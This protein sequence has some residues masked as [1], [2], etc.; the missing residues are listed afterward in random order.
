MGLDGHDARDAAAHEHDPG[1]QREQAV[2]GDGVDRALDAAELV[3]HV[4]V[5]DARALLE[6]LGGAHER[7][8]VGPRIDR[9]RRRSAADA[10]SNISSL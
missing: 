5:E 7:V 6:I 8:D 4:L 3:G 2:R 9:R 10:A 1:G